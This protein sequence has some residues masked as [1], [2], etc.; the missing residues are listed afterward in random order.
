[1]IATGGSTNTEPFAGRIGSA[2]C[3]VLILVASTP[4]SSA[5]LIPLAE[6]FSSADNTE[7]NS[8][9]IGLAHVSLV[10]IHTL[11]V[12]G[13]TS[14]VEDVS[15]IATSVAVESDSVPDANGRQEATRR[16]VA[17]RAELLALTSDGVEDTVGV[18]FAASL[19]HTTSLASRLA[20]SRS[21][22]SQPFTSSYR[23]ASTRRSETGA[24]GVTELSGDI[25]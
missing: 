13:A 20:L 2:A 11:G 3:R 14:G 12:S 4:A 19:G 22:S 24:L 17:K 16:F 6:P 8:A 7:R 5:R 21:G 25:P 15:D 10:V 9:A 23:S 18:R 1:L